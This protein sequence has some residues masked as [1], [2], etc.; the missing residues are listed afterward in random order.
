[1]FGR[2]KHLLRKAYDG[3]LL[4]D[5]DEAKQNWDHASQTEKAVYDSDN[6]LTAET[7]L[8]R[9]KYEFLYREAKRRKVHGHTQSSVFGR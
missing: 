7:Q 1:M 5:I 9:A 6:E 4:N 3:F 8:A 2:K